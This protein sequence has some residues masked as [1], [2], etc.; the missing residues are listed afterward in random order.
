MTA[1]AK[2]IGNLMG[3]LFSLLSLGLGMDKDYLETRLGKDPLCRVQANYYPPCPNPDLT[4]GLGVHTDRDALTVVLPTPNVQ[5]LQIMKDDQWIMVD[6]IPNAFV[7]NIGDQLQVCYY[8]ANWSFLFNS[9]L[10]VKL[11]SYLMIIIN[12]FYVFY[13]MQILSNG[14]YKSVLHRVVTNESERRVSLAMFY[15][16]DKDAF[17]GPIQD[18]IDEHH[19]RLY[20]D[21]YFREFLEIFRK[22]EGKNRKIKEFFEI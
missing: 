16:P 6:P 17:I 3:K 14:K 18:L 1:Y 5:G 11:N 13:W 4:L 22:Q 8:N 20:R 21:Y 12:F 7:V 19:P 2:E 10:M 9:M 15:G